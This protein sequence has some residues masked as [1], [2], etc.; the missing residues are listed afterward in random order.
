M[1]MRT[2]P[3]SG[4]AAMAL[5]GVAVAAAGAL[6]A[7]VAPADLMVP[8]WRPDNAA[9]SPHVR[10]AGDLYPRRAI[11]SDDVETEV[12]RE[13]ERL[14]SQFWSA[15][16]YLYSVVPPERVVG[17]SESAG[18]PRISNVL[19]HVARHRP[20]VAID[21]ELVLRL[22][23]DLVFT[24]DVARSDQPALLREAGLPV[25]RIHTKFETLASIAE[26][27]RL[28]GYLTG[29]DERAA[30]E[31]ERFEAA[32]RRAALR[33]PPTLEPPRV[34]GL[35]GAYSY[36]GRTLF[37]DILRVL[38]AENVAAT[39]GFV[40]Y[41]RVTDEHIVNWDP[42][43]IVAGA[44]RGRA[45]EARRRLL[46]RPAIAA[47]TAARHGRVIV[48]EHHVFLPLSPYTAALVEALADALY[49]AVS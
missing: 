35:G 18:E 24:P 12:E 39:H 47:T 8:P 17:V 30:A 5:L 4:V 9:G 6:V 41:D 23:P 20:G 37:S 26:H 29:Q 11:G 13:P 1:S 46:A 38:G 34:L 14:V 22:H 3:T 10:M 7:R 44:D 49:G 2:G 45:A 31:A 19:A 48:L 32:I 43:W 40:G 15:D 42:D 27:I 36:G 33:K 28:V 16:E 25:Y 21:P